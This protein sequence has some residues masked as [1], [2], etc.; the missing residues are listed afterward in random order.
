MKYFFLSV[1]VSIF[2]STKTKKTMATTSI[3]SRCIPGGGISSI[4]CHYDGYPE[5]NGEILRNHYRTPE[6]IESLFALGDL[7]FLGEE[8][9]FKHDFSDHIRGICK[10]YGRDRGETNTGAKMDYT[11][12]SL[13]RRAQKVGAEWVYVYIDGKW[14]YSRVTSRV[15]QIQFIE[16]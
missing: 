14:S 10:A 16:A 5:H 8:I 13:M 9:G 2:V 11:L 12:E 7:S 6:K 4:Y 3:I 15:D 1:E